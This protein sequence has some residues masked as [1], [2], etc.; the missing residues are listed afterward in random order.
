M[1]Y[2]ILV[3]LLFTVSCVQRQPKSFS[4]RELCPAFKEASWRSVKNPE[5]P[6]QALINKQK[7]AVTPIHRTF[8]F[9][10]ED[11]KIGLCILPDQTTAPGCATA[12]ATYQ[13]KQE[14]WL[15]LEQKVTICPS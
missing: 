3:T 4:L 12:Y 13:K 7:F 8:W 5:A 11:S 10:G 2:F 14:D 6:T 9:K 15:L 1:R